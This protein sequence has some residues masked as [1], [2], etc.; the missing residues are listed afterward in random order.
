MITNQKVVKVIYDLYVDG[1]E[2]G[3]E[4]LMERATEDHP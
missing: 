1:Q 4:E 2:G 3:Q